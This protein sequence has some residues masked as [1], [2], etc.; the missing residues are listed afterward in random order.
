MEGHRM[1]T[2]IDL[3]LQRRRAKRTGRVEPDLPVLNAL[4]G[5]Y[6]RMSGGLLPVIDQAARLV[7]HRDSKNGRCQAFAAPPDHGTTRAT[8]MPRA[9]R[10]A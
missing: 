10:A 1:N 4:C 3:L 7:W 2:K 6:R 8:V 9:P 5:S